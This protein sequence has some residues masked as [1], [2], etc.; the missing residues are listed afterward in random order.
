MSQQTRQ[1]NQPF[2]QV[3]FDWLT[4]TS[5][6]DVTQLWRARLAAV[7]LILMEALTL[8]ALVAGIHLIP[9]Q[10]SPNQVMLLGLAVIWIALYAVNRGGATTIAGVGIAVVLF[11]VVMLIMA[12][13]GPLAPHTIML[14]IPV[15]VA[16]LFGPP[17]AALVAAL[18]T[19]VGYV[20]LNVTADPGYFANVRA[21]G[22]ETQTVIVY[23]NL[24]FMA[25]VAW[26]F[27]R[28]TRQAISDSQ[29]TSYALVAQRDM[30]SLQL[31][32]QTRQLQATVAVSRAIAGNRDL[33]QLLDDT[34]RLVRE[35][36]GYY[37]VQVFLVDEEAGYAALRQSTGEVGKELLARGHRLAVG[38]LSVIGQVTAGGRPVIARDT[39]HD[40]VHRRNELL[41]NTRSEMALPLSIGNRVIGALD[42]QS[43][44]PDVFTE[45]FAP[46]LQALA[47]LLAIAIENARLFEQ[48]ENNLRE[49]SELSWENTQRSWSDFL[50]D[51]SQEERHQVFGPETNA[52]SVQ[53]SRIVDRA[54]SAGSVIVSTGKDGQPAFLAAPVVVRNEVVGVLGIESDTPRDWT[55]DD[56][57]LIEAIASRTA[58]AVENARLYIQA[59][60]SA[61]RERLVN[62]IATRLQRAP[63][64]SMLLESATR[65]LAEA[66]GTDTVYAEI[67]VDRPL[68]QRRK[69]V[70]EPQ[71]ELSGSDLARPDAPEEARAEL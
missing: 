4:L 1:P 53:R 38:S 64:L 8:L 57:H 61:E 62:T 3:A 49:L 67:N 27:S 37:H 17:V 12:A 9:A 58:M 36:F 45:E 7:L 23:V 51:I 48:A 59:Q 15:I 24:L 30:L 40:A 35:T 41:P 19:A 26:L 47:D 43:D 50:S 20:V 31:A 5:S 60:R 13:T 34:V 63:S 33:D 14:I 65:E 55:Q 21:G 10:G 54:L 52:L 18:I 39:D 28:S 22:P 66:L 2:W 56:V 68:S 25:L 71:D 44:S 6:S 32:N 69:Q 70:T 16:G 11:A 29:R 46:T 42:L